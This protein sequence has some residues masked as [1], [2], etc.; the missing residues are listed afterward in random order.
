MISFENYQQGGNNRTLLYILGG[1]LLAFVGY[2]VYLYMYG[3]GSGIWTGFGPVMGGGSQ[4]VDAAGHADADPDSH[5]QRPQS[6]DKMDMSPND[7]SGDWEFQNNAHVGTD[8]VEGRDPSNE[9]QKYDSHVSPLDGKTYY[10]PQ[11]MHT[12]QDY[13]TEDE[14]DF[15]VDRHTVGYNKCRLD[16]LTTPSYLRGGD[17]FF[18]TIWPNDN[19]APLSNLRGG[20][21]TADDIV[22]HGIFRSNGKFGDHPACEDKQCLY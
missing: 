5:A 14:F 15:I 19:K 16:W 13:L 4:K 8:G 10:D 2:Q 18:G 17:M 3:S 20:C 21:V 22:H 11:V 12:P 6:G 9:V 1:L 7:Y